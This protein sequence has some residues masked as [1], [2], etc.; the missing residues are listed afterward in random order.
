MYKVLV[1]GAGKTGAVVAALLS[2]E[3]TY[4]VHLADSDFTSSDF[5]RIQHQI[6]GIRTVA[7]DLSH[8]ESVKQYVE[9]HG[10]EVMIACVPDQWVVLMAEIA[11]E[12]HLHYFD[13]CE[14]EQTLAQIKNIA[15]SANTAFVSQC[16][17][18]PGMLNILI[19]DM[20]AS[21]DH[22]HN[23]KVYLGILPSENLNA[24]YYNKNWPATILIEQYGRPC[25]R[26][27]D[28]KLVEIQALEALE[29]F[30]WGSMRFEAFSSSLLLD[31]LITDFE[32]KIQNFELNSIHFPGHSQKMQ[33]LFKDLKMYKHKE[34]LRAL[35]KEVVPETIEDQ[36]LIKI[37]AQGANHLG[38][39][40][41]KTYQK[42]LESVEVN[43]VKWSA[44]QYAT[45]AGLLAVME[46]ILGQIN[47]YKGFVL[48]ENLHLLSLL[49]HR[50][51]KCFA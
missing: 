31:K 35:L 12:S 20:I 4:E 50:Y 41:C 9:K 48:Q 29:S 2:A 28:G 43:G 5:N 26:I 33:V 16:G 24:L 37:D 27:R 10:I 21:F 36:L 6:S 44:V 3:Q 46:V 30:E 42:R 7:I 45:A 13:L 1:A 23:V 22:C 40:V 51:A 19:Q 47:E 18:A 25:K 14:Q 49:N 17:L 11:A 39:K 34:E 8:K 32:N 38:E 15:G